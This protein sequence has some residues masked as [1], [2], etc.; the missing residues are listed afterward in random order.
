MATSLL[1]NFVGDEQ[2]SRFLGRRIRSRT[3]RFAVYPLFILCS[4]ADQL[5]CSANIGSTTSISLQAASFTLSVPRMCANVQNVSASFALLLAAPRLRIGKLSEEKV[6]VPYA[7]T[8]R[9]YLNVS[10]NQL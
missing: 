3:R 9:A 10:Y 5:N 8:A 7:H 1:M 6:K 2:E 4:T